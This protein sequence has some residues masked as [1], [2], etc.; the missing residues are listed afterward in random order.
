MIFEKANTAVRVIANTC[1]HY[2]QIG[3][4]VFSSTQNSDDLFKDTAF[5]TDQKLW[6]Y[7]E[8]K[9][10]DDTKFTIRVVHVTDIR[11]VKE[12]E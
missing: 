1:G 12:N 11:P 8:D 10:F 5:S 2:F 3:Q 9:D 4:T 6:W 7:L